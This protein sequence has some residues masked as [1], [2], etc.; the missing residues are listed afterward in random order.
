MRVLRAEERLSVSH[1]AY[2]GE[3]AI[4]QIAKAISGGSD[5]VASII[6]QAKNGV[7]RIL[8]REL[9]R[10]FEQVANDVDDILTKAREEASVMKDASLQK[11]L[12]IINRAHKE[13]EEIRKAAGKESGKMIAQA[14]SRVEQITIEA[15]NGASNELGEKTR[16]EAESIVAEAKVNASGIIE[17]AHRE[18][19][20]MWENFKADLDK[21]LKGTEEGTRKKAEGIIE[22]AHQE[23]AT[24]IAEARRKAEQ[25]IK[26]LGSTQ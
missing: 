20:E 8:E 25:A 12:D 22:S 19:A 1:G 23:S 24:I 5:E 16:E 7:G 6:E 2:R 4:D 14:T 9:I 13:A 21:E 15:E 10:K 17:A 3:I 11:S 18:T 26:I